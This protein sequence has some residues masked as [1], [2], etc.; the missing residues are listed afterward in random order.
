L[1]TD[2]KAES[3]HGRRLHVD[4]QMLR[5]RREE[6]AR[7]MKE[8]GI[9][10]NA[11]PRVARGRN[12]GKTRDER[13]R[14]QRRG[15]STV[16]RADVTAIAK[17]L[18]QTGVFRDPMRARLRETRKALV[19]HWMGIANMLDAQ[20]ETTLAGDVRYFAQHLPP[21]LT[22]RDLLATQFG[23]HLRETHPKVPL[24]THYSHDRSR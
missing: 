8:Q 6:F 11:T 10:A 23:K 24:S 12:K 1:P 2:E 17:Q 3:E 14:A 15:A 21:V 9:A 13:Y 22:R 4:K 16:L 7:M 5:E 19:G 20:G 18:Q